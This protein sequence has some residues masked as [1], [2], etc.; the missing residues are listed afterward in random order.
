MTKSSLS[1][2]LITVSVTVVCTFSLT[3][4]DSYVL[5]SQGSVSIN[6]VNSTAMHQIDLHYPKSPIGVETLPIGVFCA[7]L[8]RQ[9][10]RESPYLQT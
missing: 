7:S 8:K 1:W 3:M 2:K 4:L 9:K 10:K 5:V 6:P